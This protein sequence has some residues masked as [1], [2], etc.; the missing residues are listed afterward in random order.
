M[1][2]QTHAGGHELRKRSTRTAE[3]RNVPPGRPVAPN[4]NAAQGYANREGTKMPVS[5]RQRTMN[6]SLAFPAVACDS[7]G[8]HRL[9][10]EGLYA[11]SVLFDC[12]ED[13]IHNGLCGS[14][15]YVSH[16]VLEPGAS[17]QISGAIARVEN[18]IAE[19]D[20]Q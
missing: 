8:H 1:P 19:Q 15:Y 5:G 4:R 9:I 14:I 7:D 11:G 17:E 2:G 20:K 10:I 16:N 13:R 18:A 6:R 12:G 3:C